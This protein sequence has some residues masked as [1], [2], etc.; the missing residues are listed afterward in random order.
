MLYHPV[1][2]SQIPPQFIN[3]EHQP[4]PQTPI[5]TLISQGQFRHAATRAVSGLTSGSISNYDH[6]TILHL[7]H[8]RLSCLSLISLPQQA[9]LEARPLIDW[10]ARNTSTIRSPQG[11]I[12]EAQ[13]IPWPLRIL[14]HRLQTLAS[15]DQRRAV[16]TLYV[17]ATEARSSHNLALGVNDATTAELWSS[18][19]SDLGILVANS[20]ISMNELETA[21]RHLDSLPA[22]PI[23][24]VHKCL[25]WLRIGDVAA[26]ERSIAAL[27]T[28]DKPL[29]KEILQGLLSISRNDYENAVTIL[30]TLHASHPTN[31]MVTQNL[32]VC[33]LYTG[34]MAQ[35]CELLET[36]VNQGETFSALLFNLATMYELRTEKAA[37]RKA[38]LVQSVVEM[39]PQGERGWERGLVDFKL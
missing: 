34:H 16:M 22:D 5:Q 10:L 19:L 32:A 23:T 12:P 31:E 29:E 8:I 24:T 39:G 30:T 36:I 1:P 21:A 2:T 38:A 11:L 15:G 6:E 35:G 3:S 37:E 18:R 20:L 33:L 28:N 9:A 14:L 26:V 13:L 27:A 7:Y 17:L 4:S 25:L